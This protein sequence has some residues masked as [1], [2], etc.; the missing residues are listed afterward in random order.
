MTGKEKAA[1]IR[2]ALKQRGWSSRKVSVRCE[3]CTYSREIVCS[4][5]DPGVPADVVREIAE[6]YKSVR[7]CEVSGE[8]LSGGN[9]Y[10]TVGYDREVLEPLVAETLGKLS[11]EPGKVVEVWDGWF[12]ARLGLGPVYGQYKYWHGDERSTSCYDKRTAAEAVTVA[13]LSKP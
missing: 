8:L 3:P 4:I 1:E 10:I 6:Q 2:K 7:Y 12:V 11:D 9:T 13:R 5:K